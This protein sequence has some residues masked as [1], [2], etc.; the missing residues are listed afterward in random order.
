MQLVLLYA[1]AATQPVLH[2]NGQ[3]TLFDH[4]REDKVAVTDVLPG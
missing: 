2:A 3:L 1:R 4:E